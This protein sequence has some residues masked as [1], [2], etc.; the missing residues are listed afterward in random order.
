MTCLDISGDALVSL[1]FCLVFKKVENSSILIIVNIALV[2]SGGM[3]TGENCVIQS[4]IMV[5]HVIK[6]NCNN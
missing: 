2:P 3:L 1:I 6:V 5:E 4:Y